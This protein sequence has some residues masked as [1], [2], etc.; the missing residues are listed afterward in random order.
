MSAFSDM[1]NKL[2]CQC[3]SCLYR[4]DCKDIPHQCIGADCNDCVVEMSATLPVNERSGVVFY[5]DLDELHGLVM[6]CPYK[7]EV[8]NEN[9]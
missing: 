8:K 2:G 7:K 4:T 1:C 6:K 5:D 9:S 3:Y